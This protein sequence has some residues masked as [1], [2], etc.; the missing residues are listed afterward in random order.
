MNLNQSQVH[1]VSLVKTSG[2]QL[3]QNLDIGHARRS[4]IDKY[5]QF[6]QQMAGTP[7]QQAQPVR[8]YT[9]QMAKYDRGVP[10]A[11]QQKAHVAAQTRQKPQTQARQAPQIQSRTR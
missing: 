11:V 3:R 5:D 8:T 7:R 4:S 2:E 6:R 1:R 9:Q 10:A